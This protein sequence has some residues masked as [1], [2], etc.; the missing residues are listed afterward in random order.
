[1]GKPVSMNGSRVEHLRK[2][3]LHLKRNLFAQATPL[4][5][6]LEE[7]AALL[8]LTQDGAADVRAASVDALTK[9]GSVFAAP[10]AR[11]LLDDQNGLVRSRAAETLG[12]SGKSLD[13]GRLTRSL[14]D[15]AW[16]VRC[17]AAT[18]LGQL[19]LSKA[20]PVLAERLSAEGH[21][22]VV[23]DLAWAIT[24]VDY[25]VPRQKLEAELRRHRDR[26]AR[27]G[28]LFALWYMY[29]TG[30][31]FDFA[32]KGDA[33]VQENSINLV[34]G[35]RFNESQQSQLSAYLRNLIGLETEQVV[36]LRA[37]EVLRRIS[38]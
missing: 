12:L 38:K 10:A 11:S 4:P 31:F 3:A 15:R 18:A 24:Q 13:L 27:T 28:I 6:S 21:P 16:V 29:D 8:L 7:E 19:R 33:L 26:I 5:S 22:T 30:D 23:R 20:G 9:A 37:T 14:Q 1:M 34:D 35:N 25:D 17:A 36:K 32:L 2:L